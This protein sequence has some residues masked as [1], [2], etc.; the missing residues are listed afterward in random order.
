M[1][2]K[3][4]DMWQA[5]IPITRKALGERAIEMR[6]TLNEKQVIESVNRTMTEFADEEPSNADEL[7]MRL[8]FH[9]DDVLGHG[10]EEYA[11]TGDEE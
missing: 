5:M 1:N 10:D 8:E 11:Y 9:A 3:R 7:L 2:E 6:P 4:N